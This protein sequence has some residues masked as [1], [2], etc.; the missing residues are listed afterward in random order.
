MSLCHSSAAAQAAGLQL[1]NCP[2]KVGLNEAAFGRNKIFDVVDQKTFSR[3]RK[4]FFIA[5]DGSL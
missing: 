5:V 4:L 2:I 1:G 3:S